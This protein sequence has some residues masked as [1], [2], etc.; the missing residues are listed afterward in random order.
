[1]TAADTILEQ[2]KDFVNSDNFKTFRVLFLQRTGESLKTFDQLVD[3]IGA[4]LITPQDI[5]EEK[6]NDM[7]LTEDQEDFWLDNL[8]MFDYD[9]YFPPMEKQV[10][11]G[12]VWIKVRTKNGFQLHLARKA[13][14]K[15]NFHKETLTSLQGLIRDLEKFGLENEEKAAKKR[16][17][18]LKK[19]MQLKV[20]LQPYELWYWRT[21][22]QKAYVTPCEYEVIDIQE[23]IDHVQ[24]KSLEGVL[25]V[26]SL[27]TAKNRD[28]IFY[29]QSRGISAEVAKIFANLD[30]CYFDFNVVKGMEIVNEEMREA[31]S[32]QVSL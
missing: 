22:T 12:S 20:G 23:W 13:T 14:R 5:F 8:E 21:K 11:N 18:S 3:A 25:T 28:K 2:L 24:N 29:L 31:F 32:S 15:I 30:Q 17:D 7:E 9:N 27:F 10:Q 19:Q 16:N 26:R 1:M 4:K 6:F